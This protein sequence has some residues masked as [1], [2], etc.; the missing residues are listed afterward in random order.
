[1]I[2]TRRHAEWLAVAF[3][4]VLIAVAFHQIYTAMTE[5]G[6]ASGGPYDNAAAYPKAVAILIG[7]LIAGQAVV[8]VLGR[9]GAGDAMSLVELGRPAAALLIF[10][11]YLFALGAVGYHLATPAMI[12]SVMIL[13]GFRNPLIMVGFGAGVSLMIA[14]FFEGQLKVVLPGGMFGLNIPW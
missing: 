9:K 11:I 6:I 1:M 13:S 3:F 2:L 10:A 14:Y 7:V 5:Q 12:V 8:L 4:A